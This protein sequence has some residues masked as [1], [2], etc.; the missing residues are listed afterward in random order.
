MAEGSLNH[1][2][3]RPA[4]GA[5][6]PAKKAILRAQMAALARRIYGPDQSGSYYRELAVNLLQTRRRAAGR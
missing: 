2:S 5:V 6:R 1:L 3:L 4:A